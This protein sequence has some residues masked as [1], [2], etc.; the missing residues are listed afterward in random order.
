MSFLVEYLEEKK[1]KCYIYGH[2]LVFRV[3]G[4][5]YWMDGTVLGKE[6][7]GNLIIM[8]EVDEEMVL[9]MPGI[10]HSLLL[11]SLSRNVN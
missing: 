8:Y 10:Y 5:W 4:S 11:E 3:S 6:M 1:K 9:N 7:D 2:C